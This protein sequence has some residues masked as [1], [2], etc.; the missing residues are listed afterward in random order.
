MHRRTLGKLTQAA[1]AIYRKRPEANT[2]NPFLAALGNAESIVEVFPENW[3]AVEL[4]TRLA[5][6]WNH[7]YGGC[8]GLNY[9]VV[10]AMIDRL[11]LD[12]TA[13]KHMFEDIQHLE[14]VALS[15]MSKD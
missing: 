6:Q 9:L 8:T 13:A 5:T 12:K 4:F 10:F 15:E 2:A 3:A 11:E 14:R 7:T 1:E